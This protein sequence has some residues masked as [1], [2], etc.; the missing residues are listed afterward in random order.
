MLGVFLQYWDP[1]KAEFPEGGEA[2]ESVNV[3]PTADLCG[4]QIKAEKSVHSVKKVRYGSSAMRRMF[5]RIFR[6]S[7]IKKKTF[8]GCLT[9]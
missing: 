9:F 6:I 5:M 3:H 7:E 8:I 4:A 1:L 2:T